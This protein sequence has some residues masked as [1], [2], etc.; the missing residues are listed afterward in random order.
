MELKNNLLN[1]IRYVI[2]SLVLIIGAITIFYFVTSE[3]D[4]DLVTNT[5]PCFND[6]WKERNSNFTQ[7][8]SSEY[9]INRALDHLKC[10]EYKMSI[11][12][13]NKSITVSENDPKK[14]DW[15]LTSNFYIAFINFEMGDFDEAEAFYSSAIQYSDQ[16]SVRPK[17]ELYRSRA[18]VYAKLS[19]SNE[20]IAD[21]TKAI[22]LNSTLWKLYK[23]RSDAYTALDMLDE[24]VGDLEMSEKLKRSN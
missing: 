13:F 18:T 14:Y 4:S 2:L 22:E 16:S 9:H 8:N 3:T 19:K 20:A 10:L 15:L 5:S 24:A 1:N 21:Y 7:K 11:D 17:W 23:E 6:A 12:E